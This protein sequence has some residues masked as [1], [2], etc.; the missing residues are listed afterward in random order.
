MSFAAPYGSRTRHRVTIKE[1][2]RVAAMLASEAGF[3]VVT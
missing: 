1:I 3:H 2:G